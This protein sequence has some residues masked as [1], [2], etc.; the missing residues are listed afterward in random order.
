MHV[1]GAI[2]QRNCKIEFHRKKSCPYKIYLN[3]IKCG[4]KRTGAITLVC[5]TFSGRGSITVTRT[6]TG[7]RYMYVHMDVRLCTY[8]YTREAGCC[9]PMRQNRQGIK[10]S[11][12]C[13]VCMPSRDPTMF[14]AA[15][16]EIACYTTLHLYTLCTNIIY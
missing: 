4:M 2:C 9:C 14:H 5:K 7:C 16:I 3:S 12:K 13:C 10:N 15:G 8:I 1:Y 11:S 6:N